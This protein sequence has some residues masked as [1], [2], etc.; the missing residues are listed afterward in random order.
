MT[1]TIRGQVTDGKEPLGRV[2]LEA[3]EWGYGGDYDCLGNC[4][5]D[6]NGEYQF[7][8][9]QNQSRYSIRASLLG[10]EHDVFFVIS[11]EYRTLK[12]RTEIVT[13]RDNNPLRY[14]IKVTDSTSFDDPYKDSSKR[15]VSKFALVADTLDPLKLI[16]ERGIDAEIG[17]LVRVIERFVLFTN[18]DVMQGYGYLGPQVPERPTIELPHSEEIPWRKTGKKNE[19]MPPHYL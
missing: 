5:T 14:D 9:E 6:K 4:K 2:I 3:F 19:E 10:P 18:R 16:G 13:V 15:M 17:R 1:F 7:S 11:D 8:F 12:D